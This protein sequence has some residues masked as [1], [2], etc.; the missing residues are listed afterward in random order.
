[1]ARDRS[2]KFL[3]CLVGGPQLVGGPGPGPPGPP[4]KSGP[5]VHA[6]YDSFRSKGSACTPVWGGC[7]TPQSPA[8]IPQS[9]K[10]RYKLTKFS[11]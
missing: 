7:G 5:G 3:E 6:V 2:Q 8:G 11:N 10:L 1:M 4:P 9:F